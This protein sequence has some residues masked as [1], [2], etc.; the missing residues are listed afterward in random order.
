M[1]AAAVVTQL[2][3]YII[4]KGIEY[5]YVCI[6]QTFVFLYILN[7]PA[8]IY[9]HMC[10]LNLDVINDDKNKLHCT[11]VAQVFAFILQALRTAPPPLS[12][13]DAAAGPSRNVSKSLRRRPARLS[14]A[15]RRSRRTGTSPCSATSCVARLAPPTGVHM[16]SYLAWRTRLQQFQC[17]SIT[18]E[19]VRCDTLGRWQC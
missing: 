17:A 10:V 12:W 5:K 7:N 13:H 19:A 9:H 14:A 18:E 2:F 3:S 16:L 11:A 4:G 6:G 1:L 8:A 15:P